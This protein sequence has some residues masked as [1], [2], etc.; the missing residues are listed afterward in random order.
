MPSGHRFCMRGAPAILMTPD[1]YHALEQ[2]TLLNNGTGTQYALGLWIRLKPE[3]RVLSHGGKVPGFVSVH[4]IYPDAHAF[5][6]TKVLGDS[7]TP[8]S[9]IKRNDVSFRTWVAPSSSVPD[10][11]LAR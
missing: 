4:V 3:R 9:E 7:T 8:S 11:S 6:R 10:G 2:E 1:A 5:G